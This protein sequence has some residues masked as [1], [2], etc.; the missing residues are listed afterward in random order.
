M[1]AVREIVV[2]G[3][4]FEEEITRF[5]APNRLC[6]RIVKSKPLTIDHEGGDMQLSSRDGG[7]Q[8]DWTTTMA[9]K[10]PLFGGVLT[11]ILGRVIQRK[12]GQFLMWAKQDLER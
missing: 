5:D 9:V 3:S 7:T 11:K 8:V 6:Y 2:M 10:M 12:F 4:S 1:G